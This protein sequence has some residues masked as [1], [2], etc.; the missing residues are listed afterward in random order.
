MMTTNLKVS[1]LA[2]SECL[3]PADLDEILA[4]QLTIAWA[5][6]GECEPKR[7]GWW[8]TDL[9]DPAGGGYLFQELFPE[10]H[11]WASLEAV[12]RA[13]VRCDREARAQRAQPDKVRTLYFWGFRLDEKLEERLAVLK[14]QGQTPAE[15]LSLSFEADSTFQQADLEESLRAAC[16]ESKTRVVPGGREVVGEIP[17]ALADQARRLAA[18]LLPFPDEY[19]APFFQL[20]D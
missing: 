7:L 10:T 17:G 5:G 13:A 12:R 2:E 14:Q 3:A 19:P 9:V 15:V 11:L 8:R 18:A 16:T 20:R 4:L 1:S 6:E